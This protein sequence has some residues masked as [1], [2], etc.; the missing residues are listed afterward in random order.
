MPVVTAF[1]FKDVIPFGDAASETRGTH[2]GFGATRDKAHLFKERNCSSDQGCQFELQFRRYAETGAFGGLI[3]DGCRYGRMRV[4]EEHG[5]PGADI[6]E[7][8]IA[9]CIVKILTA[10]L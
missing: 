1:E 3:R 4:T 7:E 5:A 6:I 2:S 8:P 10:S 9:V